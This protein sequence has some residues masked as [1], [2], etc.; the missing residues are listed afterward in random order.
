[1]VTLRELLGPTVRIADGGVGTG[2]QAC[3]LEAGQP[4]EELP[5][6]RPLSEARWR[7]RS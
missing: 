5:G 2:L 3:S 7:L 6:L 1:M 4:P